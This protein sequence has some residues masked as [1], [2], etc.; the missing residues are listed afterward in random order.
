L[1][2]RRRNELSVR[3]TLEPLAAAQAATR[4]TPESLETFWRLIEESDQAR[5]KRHYLRVRE[6]NARF[7]EHLAVASENRTLIALMAVLPLRPPFF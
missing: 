1:G 3:A 2:R 5:L 6:L 7:H 4:R